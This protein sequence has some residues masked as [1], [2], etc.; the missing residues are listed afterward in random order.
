MSNIPAWSE[1]LS[2]GNVHVDQQ[3][4]QLISLCNRAADC[5]ASPLPES[6][7]LFHA[8]LNELAT[9]VSKHFD[10]EEI[11]RVIEKSKLEK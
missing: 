10:D 8:I 6:R 4:Q 2:V 5:A 7:G 3:H 9:L 1:S 11:L